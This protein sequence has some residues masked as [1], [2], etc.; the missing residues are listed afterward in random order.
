MKPPDDNRMEDE[1]AA[2]NLQRKKPSWRGPKAVNGAPT[3]RQLR[4][5]SEHLVILVEAGLIALLFLIGWLL[6]VR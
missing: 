3:K 6:G 2:I 1:K 5:G 4:P